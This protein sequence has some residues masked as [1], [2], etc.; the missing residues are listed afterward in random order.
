M[1]YH[2]RFQSLFF[3]LAAS[4][5]VA[6]VLTTHAEDDLHAIR[7]RWQPGY[8]YK[9][10]TLTETTT[11]L[12][13]I[14]QKE[15]QKM[16]I[17][18]TTEIEVT[19]DPEAEKRAKVTFKAL[20]GDVML[21]G[22]K[23]AFDSADMSAA[24]PMIKAS[25]GKSVGKTFVLV[26]DAADK[27]VEVRDTSSMSASPDG[28]VALDQVAEANEVADL[29]RRSLE[30]GLPKMAV[31]AGDRWTSLET[32]KF[33]SAG[34]VNIE[35]HAKMEAVVDYEGHPNAKISFEGEMKRADQSVG[36]RAVTIG[37]G[38]KT[39][40]QILF[41]LDRGT[42]TLGTFRADIKLEI[43][44]KTVPVRQQVTTKLIEM[45]KK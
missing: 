16:T 13:S 32:V 41:D 27:F 33:P 29:Y 12:T 24:D 42:V 21:S 19:G 14:G 38:S 6:P 25:V 5:F 1:S 3:T 22:K 10:A 2:P 15:D 28:I 36:T 43:G 39:F 4:F 18:Q 40:G 45:V 34:T 31:K 44:G 26:Y 17:R 20:S 37:N 30:M 35:L 8:V 11:G 23:H 7:L 9:Q